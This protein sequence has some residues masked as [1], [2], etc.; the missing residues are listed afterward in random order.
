MSYLEFYLIALLAPLVVWAALFAL[1]AR[2]VGATRHRSPATSVAGISV[3]GK[4]FSL[5]EIETEHA[6]IRRVNA[7][8]EEDFNHYRAA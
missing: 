3:P 6:E 1:M 5:D 2:E 7:F 4:D 8:Y